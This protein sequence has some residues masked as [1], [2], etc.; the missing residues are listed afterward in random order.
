MKLPLLARS[1]V[2]DLMS[3]V[4]GTKR[5]KSSSNRSATKTDLERAS[6]TQQFRIYPIHEYI[7]SSQHDRDQGQTKSV[8]SL[9]GLS[10]GISSLIVLLVFHVR[11]EALAFFWVGV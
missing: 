8:P 1:I 5:G 3:S 7:S 4:V 2:G 6:N 10:T 9:T 11:Q